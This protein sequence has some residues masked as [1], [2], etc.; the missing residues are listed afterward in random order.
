MASHPFLNY[1]KVVS[2]FFVVILLFSLGFYLFFLPETRVNAQEQPLQPYFTSPAND[3]FMST[4]DPLYTKV[5]EDQ[6]QI[7]VEDLTNN[8][9]I[10]HT[11][12]DYSPDGFLWIPIGEDTY[13]GFE[14]IQFTGNTGEASTNA[15][16]G[17][18][19]NIVWDTSSISE[20]YYILRATMFT[21]TGQN[22]S[23]ELNIHFDPT[24]PFLNI[25]QTPSIAQGILGPLET[26]TNLNATTNDEDPVTLVL[27]Y[28]DASRPEIDQQGL[29]DADQENVG[30]PNTNGTPQTDD[31]QNNFCGPTSAANALWR[32]GQKDPALL[33]SSSGGQLQ[34][35]TQLAEELGNETKTD[36]VNGTASD[37]M[38]SG[39]RK[40]L[41]KRNLDNNYTVKPH[42][43]KQGGRGPW[44]SDVGLALRQGEAVILLK[45]QPGADGIVGTKD[46]I[47]H[48]ETGKD[49]NPT[50]G[51]QG[52]GE[53]SVRDPRGPTDKSGKV[54]VVPKNNNFEGIWFDED[55]DGQQDPG[56]VWYLLAFWE[57]SPQNQY[58]WDLQSVQYNMLGE[59]L[60]PSDGWNITAQT[61]QISDGFYLLRARMFDAT[62]NV[63]MNRTTL[64][65]NNKPP[66]PVTLHT[67][68]SITT[69]SATL[70][71]TINQD[72]DFKIYQIYLSQ[73]PQTTGTNIHNI[74]NYT[75]TTTTINNLN[76]QTTYYVT[77]QVQDHSNQ[78]STLSQPA[79]FTT[80]TPTPT[81]TPTSTPAPTP[82]PT[83]APTPSPTT[84]PSP[85]PIPTPTPQ[86]NTFPTELAATIAI[87][88][89]IT[90]TTLTLILR[91]KFK[92]TKP[93]NK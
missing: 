83:P 41:K 65:I 86:P 25:D 20:N 9:N 32:L 15:W 1:N 56:E 35:A 92:K 10:T 8:Q 82:I 53:V 44:W 67:P 11:I 42:I 49:A 75:S 59:D 69:T 16:G 52:G 2:T 38:T 85:T 72:E 31:D 70:S 88:T 77:I 34:N 60:N 5:Y 47:G 36:P 14:G 45:V 61:T 55:G 50:Y 81:P 33:Q 13:S 30:T 54:K 87:G 76:S 79:I 12:F 19:W 21:S 18:G 68:T 39:L 90:A 71:W 84:N 74:N 29:G 48:Y 89:I 57:V 3:E 66:N 91:N 6:V 93:Q 78:T 26:N 23:A 46:D 40:F 64:Y 7:R 58:T 17:S 63:G 51:P 4:V 27:D 24:P 43:P 22:A 62:G 73:N 80:Q 28:I 37:D